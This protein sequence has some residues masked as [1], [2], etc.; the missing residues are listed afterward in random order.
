MNRSAETPWRWLLAMALLALSALVHAETASE[1]LR[2]RLE[3]VLGSGP[4]R[5]EDRA[6]PRAVAEFYAARGW[7]PAWD[8]ERYRSLLA[9][10]ASVHEDGLDPADYSLPELQRLSRPDAPERIAEREIVATRAL[11]RALLHLYRGKVD[12]V[13]LDSHWNFDARQIDPER[14]LH[15]VLEGV[16]ANRLPEL[17]ERARPP[18]AYYRQ[19]R[20]A[21]AGL[22]R[23]E[24]DGGWPEL[25]PGPVLAPGMTD[26]RLPLLRR[27]L[28]LGGLLDTS[29][30]GE[31]ERYDEAV[32]RA[33]MRFQQDANLAAD[34]VV[35]SATREQL[36]VP[37]GRRIAQVRVNL[38]RMRWF[39][40]AL[41][42]RA[43]IV[44]LAGYRVLYLQE[45]EL[46]WSGR[47]QIGREY[48]QTPVF[49]SRID[50]LTLS[51]AWVVPPTIL[52]EDILPEVR[53]DPG[54]LAKRRL[55]VI[56]KR[57]ERIPPSSVN[58]ERPGDIAL[59]QEPGPGGALGEIVIRFDNPYAI[60]LHD[61]PHKELFD[62]NRRTTSSGCIRVQ[63]VHELALLLLNDPAWDRAALERIIAERKT[64][65]VRLQQKVPILIGYWTVQ[66]EPDGHLAY[67]P[68]V[69]RRD[70]PVLRALDR[71]L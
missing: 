25:P 56:N 6:T 61:T 32:R 11:L 21:L 14:G 28:V 2:A 46:K 7:R 38:E 42:G 27:R 9:M 68:D 43:V 63:N 70:P 67:R 62:I 24:A 37:V 53:R 12:P 4:L 54:Y 19:L 69:Y 57:G 52:K 30:G 22:R 31:P 55:Q 60:Y 15:L 23:I 1:L 10:L 20:A 13:K 49:Q 3:G 71:P 50:H 64:L 34:G 36:N 5:L 47:V 35:G 8:D 29:A 59:R 48:R 44:D 58:W 40:A 26:A 51:P 33:V 66:V 17:F 16:A 39:H 18:P 65:S 45:D 41:K